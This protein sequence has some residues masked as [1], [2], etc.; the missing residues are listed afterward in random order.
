MNGDRDENTDIVNSEDKLEEIARKNKQLKRNILI[1]FAAMLAFMLICIAIPGFV[2]LNSILGS[3]GEKDEEETLNIVFSDIPEDGF[4]I[5]K[6]K[7]YLD[8]DRYFYYYD[9]DTGVT[10]TVNKKDIKK[11]GDGFEVIY[12]MVNALI[13]GDVEAYN[14]CMGMGVPDEDGFTQQQIYDIKIT[15]KGQSSQYTDDGKLY[16]QYEFILE[17]KIQENNGTFRR[18]MG[19]DVSKPQYL[20][21]ADLS[22]EMCIENIL[23]YKTSG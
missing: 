12:K 2:D 14:E 11:Y 22:G 5:L 18:D 20:V 3:E 9:P 1:V 19:S 10:T 4:D 7:K 8:Q 13:E 17:Y 6:Y 15:K 16:N 23:N 21:I